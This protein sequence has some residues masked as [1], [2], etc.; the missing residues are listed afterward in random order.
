MNDSAKAKIGTRRFLVLAL[1][2]AWPSANSAQETANPTTAR[3]AFAQSG[4]LAQVLAELQ[5][6]RTELG[7][8]HA[9]VNQ[10]RTQQQASEVETAE[11]KKELNAAK[12]E[13][14]AQSVN[15]SSATA[16]SP[17]NSDN[18]ERIARL[19]ENQQMSDQKLAVQDQSKVE[20]GSKYRLRL[21][22]ILLVNLFGNQGTVDNL[23][24]PQLAEPRQFIFNDRSFGGSV[25]QSQIS[26]QAFGP[27]LAGAR[28]S[29]DLQF[30]FAGGFPAL[31]NG[32]AFG[33]MR[34]RTGT[35]RFD[36][37]DTSIVGGQDT[38]F[39]APLAPT[40]IASIATP[41]LSYSGN[42]W[43]WTPQVRVEHTVEVSD[44][45]RLKF[46]GGIL[47]PWSGDFPDSQ[48]MRS[49][50]WGESSGVPA[51][52]GRV[53]WTQKIGSRD[54]TL[55][56]G[57]YF[58]R[59]DWGFQRSVDS[60]LSSF[61]LM[62]PLGTRFEFSGQ[63][64]RGRALGGL[65]GG[66]GQSVIWNGSL[67]DPTVAVHGL[68]AMGGWAQFKYRATPKLQFNSAFGL[69]NPFTYQLRAFG[70]NLGPYSEIYSKN[71]SGFVN[72]IYQPRSDLLFSFEYRRIWTFQLDG[73]SNTANHLNLSMGYIF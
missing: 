60:W 24:F 46:Q 7:A 64:Y 16:A 36:W 27:T 50:T 31:P 18:T 71:Q 9:E 57:G 3:Q 73:T 21:S 45:A 15:N 12:T 58:S 19:E 68:D 22:G 2:M 28:T 63:F 40:S 53:G 49:A 14:A 44:S 23:D 25:R 70:S 65:G 39:I 43:S 4:D 17:E 42:L 52:A 62:L 30:D 56:A 55:G 38:L 69:D 66:I 20:S 26:L 59:Q 47:D 29:A 35:V 41:P 10:L 67:A 48:Y 54:F 61:D 11:L 34:L 13:V 6:L 32:V 1:L 5:K 37:T 8:L 72:F 51:V 33:I